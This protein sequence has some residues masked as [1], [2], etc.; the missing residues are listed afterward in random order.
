MKELKL[1]K[2]T[3]AG[4]CFWCTEAVFQRLEGVEEVSSGFTGGE[5]K[6]PA[7]REIITGRT[8]HAE[9]IEIQFNPEK[10][11]FE[12]LLLVFF[13][14]HDPTT[15]NKQQ[16]DV[17][18]QYRSAVFYHDEDQKIKAEEV[19]ALLE[20]EGMFENPIVTE[21]SEASEFYVAE[22]EHQDFYNQHRQQPYCQFIID[23][24]IKKLNKL[25]SD[26]LK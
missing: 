2:A 12:E 9:A 16:N 13:A 22:A 3:L 25:F 10:I 18:T 8:G 4:G 23:P 15:L 7:Y 6:N 20:K 5:I 1:K 17:G 19:I 11:S 24:K 26:K 21:V 14:T